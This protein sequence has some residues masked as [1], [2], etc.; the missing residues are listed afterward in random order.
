MGWKKTNFNKE[1]IET[2][3]TAINGLASH[4]LRTIAIG[5]KPISSKTLFF[6][7]MK[8]KRI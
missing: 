6:M 1:S 2:I 5:F 7:K 4:A 8:P 3:Q